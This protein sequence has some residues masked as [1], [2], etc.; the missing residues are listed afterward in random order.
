MSQNFCVSPDMHPPPQK[1]TYVENKSQDVYFQNEEKLIVQQCFISV[2][3][4]L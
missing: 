2:T 4:F 1:S 3:L